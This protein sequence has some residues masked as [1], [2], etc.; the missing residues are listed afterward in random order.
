M[1]FGK[2]VSKSI[3]II[4]VSFFLKS[5]RKQSPSSNNTCN[6]TD[7]SPNLHNPACVGGTGQS[8]QSPR[9]LSRS[10]LRQCG[11][12]AFHFSAADG[13]I[14]RRL[15]FSSLINPPTYQQGQ[16]NNHNRQ[17]LNLMWHFI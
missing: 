14:S 12:P 6:T 2:V 13:I 9:R 4:F 1:F 7:S 16:V 11:N 17:Y 10:S 15:Y 5:P 8:K 3:Y